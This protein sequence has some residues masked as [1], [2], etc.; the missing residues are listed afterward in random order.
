MTAG[1]A[2]ALAVGLVVG[3]FA[4]LGWGL[5]GWLGAWRLNRPPPSRPEANFTFTPWELGV[6]FEPV[7]LETADGVA[8]E[9]WFLPR[10]SSRRVVVAM[11]GYRGN[12]AQILG[13]SSYLWRA[14]FNVLL[15]DFR[16]RGGS[17]RAPFSMGCWEVEDLVAAL[18]E[19][20]ARVE[21][22][23]I[24]LLGYS[25]GGAVAIL[26]GSDPRVAAIV[27]DSS[28][29]S[30]R[31]VLESVAARDARRVFGTRLDGRLFLPAVEWWHRRMGKPAFDDI[32][33]EAALPVLEGTPILFIHG[34]RDGIVPLVLAERL[35]AAA[36]EPHETWFVNGA[37]HCGA[38]FLDRETYCT[39]VAAFFSRHLG[40]EKPNP[41]RGEV[42]RTAVSV[43][44]AG[45]EPKRA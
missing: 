6:E 23:T 5:V 15:F 19:A 40:R 34:T 4:F 35:V 44:Q 26:G 28:F 36:R 29:P 3:G 45:E 7:E 32:A 24:G 31:A 42:R 39:R 25:V 41:A 8:L 20:S 10:P 16:G 27:V 43:P 2:I 1:L 11:H 38:Y 13:I 37:S 9:G 12:K 17:Q 30:Q 22:A 21:D 14:G 33:P 18:E